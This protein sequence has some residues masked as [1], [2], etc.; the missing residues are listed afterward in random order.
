[1]DP[2][3]DPVG[4]KTCGSCG[5]GSPTTLPCRKRKNRAFITL[6]FSQVCMACLG[7]GRVRDSPWTPRPDPWGSPAGTT[8]ACRSG[9]PRRWRISAPHPFLLDKNCT[10]R[11]KNIN[12]LSGLRTVPRIQDVHPGSKFFHPG[13]RAKKIPDP[14]QRI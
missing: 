2:N 10:T 8:S 12:F 3:P 4:P 14:H 1:M 9:Q 7:G 6:S 11:T 5:S 13:S